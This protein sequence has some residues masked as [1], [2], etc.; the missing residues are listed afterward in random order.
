MPGMQ[1]RGT[2][3]DGEFLTEPGRP[4]LAPCCGDGAARLGVVGGEAADMFML[5]AKFASREVDGRKTS[6]LWAI[7]GQWSQEKSF[8]GS[9]FD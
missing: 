5:P 2:D 7:L 8:P 3:T 6:L 9:F 1:L 4:R